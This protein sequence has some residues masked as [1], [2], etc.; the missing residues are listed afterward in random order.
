MMR[1]ESGVDECLLMEVGAAN[2]L[3]V[4]GRKPMVSHNRNLDI[5]RPPT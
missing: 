3:A 1:R 4:S 2:R 5:D